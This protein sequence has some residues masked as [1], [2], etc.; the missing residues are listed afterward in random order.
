MS[1]LIRKLYLRTPP[2]KPRFGEIE[3]MIKRPGYLKWST[4]RFF[5]K[6]WMLEKMNRQMQIIES[7]SVSHTLYKT[8]FKANQ[9]Y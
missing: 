6:C 3:F 2:N 1:F 7:G 4:Y 8:Q 5:N 9:K